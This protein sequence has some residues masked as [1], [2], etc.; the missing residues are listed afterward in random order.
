VVQEH[1]REQHVHAAAM[2]DGDHLAHTRP[3]S[4]HVAPEIELVAAINADVRVA[5]VT[6][7]R[8]LGNTPD[9]TSIQSTRPTDLNRT[10]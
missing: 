2:E 1:D 7:A 3:A 5:M 4:R 8:K 10:P 6:L 9:S